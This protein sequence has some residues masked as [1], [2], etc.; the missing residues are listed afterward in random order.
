MRLISQ[1]QRL[2]FAYIKAKSLSIMAIKEITVFSFSVPRTRKAEHDLSDLISKMNQ[3]KIDIAF[4]TGF[5]A[6]NKFKIYCVTS[7]TAAFG[8][9]LRSAGRRYVKKFRGVL[10]SEYK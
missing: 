8:D 7:D 5:G 9:F 1:K 10:Q 2:V 6:G 3:S 4:M